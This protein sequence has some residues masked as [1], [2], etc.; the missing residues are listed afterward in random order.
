ME[1]Q[2]ETKIFLCI[3]LRN[4]NYDKKANLNNISET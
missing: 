2:N 4:E 1:K 3:G